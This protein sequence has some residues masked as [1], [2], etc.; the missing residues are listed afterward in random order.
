MQMVEEGVSMVH[1]IVWKFIFIAI[2]KLNLHGSRHAS[3]RARSPGESAA[4]SPRQDHSTESQT[5][6]NSD[7]GPGKEQGSQLRQRKELEHLNIKIR[8]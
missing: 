5:A 1:F 7:S 8:S 6:Q 3:E 2:T 4:E